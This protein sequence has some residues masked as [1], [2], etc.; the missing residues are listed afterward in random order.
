MTLAREAEIRALGLLSQPPPDALQHLV[1]A[2]VRVTGAQS[3]RVNVIT[4][5]KQ[6]TLASATGEVESHD[7]EDSLCANVVRG[8]DRQRYI[9]DLNQDAQ[10]ASNPYVISGHVTSYAASQLVSRRG[11][12]I[13]TLC[14][15]SADHREVAPEALEVL[16]DLAAAVMVIL[17]SNSARDELYD[18]VVELAD[19]SREL[20][21]SNEH[22][23]AFAGQVSHDLKGPLSALLMSLELIDDDVVERELP[24][25]PHLVYLLHRAITASHRMQAMIGSLMDFAALGGAIALA[26][27]DL[28]LVVKDVVGDLGAQAGEARV[29]VGH[30]P[31]VCGDEVQL[32]ALLQN[33]VANAFKYAGATA[34]THVLVAGEH[35]DGRTRISV[36][37]NGPGVPAAER[38]AVFGIMVRGSDAKGGHVEGLGIGLATCR[39]IAQAHGGAIG[40]DESAEGGAEFWFEVP[41]RAE[42]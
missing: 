25:P 30:L 10:T 9:P 33:L 34:E 23:A 27:V 42:D 39:R 35:R 4:G 20:R 1:T 11:V 24:A 15:Y 6:H 16:S 37:D 13:G 41:D 38:D 22:L 36:S 29:E 14:V 3:A 8:P 5:T 40:V 32:R 12:P 28:E 2:A 31:T 17:E 7:I 21:R 26:P 18:V 19:G